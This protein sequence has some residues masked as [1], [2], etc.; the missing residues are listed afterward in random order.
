LS[1]QNALAVRAQS[2]LAPIE[3]NQPQ[4]DLLKRTLAASRTQLANDELALFIAVCKRTQLD[5]FLK[6]IYAI[7]DKGGRLII[8]VGIDG[9]RSV[10]QRTGQVNGTDGPYWCGPDGIWRDVWLSGDNPAAAKFTVYR[11]GHANG[12]TAVA[13]WASFK[14]VSTNWTDRPD[15]QLAKVAEDHAF[16]RAFPYEMA[17]MPAYQPEHDQD[18]DDALDEAA[19][20]WEALQ[21]P[22]RA[23]NGHETPAGRPATPEPTPEPAEGVYAELGEKISDHAGDF[24]REYADVLDEPEDDPT[25]KIPDVV[26]APDTPL[27]GECHALFLRAQGWPDTFKTM[28]L[29]AVEADEREWSLFLDRWAEPVKNAEKAA[30]RRAQTA[31]QRGR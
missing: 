14:G 26:G 18:P 7:K 31:T 23:Q 11:K 5:P 22:P 15:H 10:A 28:K 12:Y 30:E 27:R 29:P 9:R 13:R 6:Q 16:R 25:P 17:G 21:A 19:E 20:E 1:E 2:S 3:W 8:H 4:I 24:A